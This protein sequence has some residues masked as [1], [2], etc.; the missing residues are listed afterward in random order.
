M[1]AALLREVTDELMGAVRD[2]LAD[3]RGEPAPTGFYRRGRTGAA[4]VPPGQE[5]QG[6]GDAAS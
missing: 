3:V 2:L 1:D 6:E 5:K 4:E